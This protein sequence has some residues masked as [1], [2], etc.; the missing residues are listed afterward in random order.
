M[1]GVGKALGRA[2]RKNIM[3]R[4]AGSGLSLLVG[5]VGLARDL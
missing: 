5:L 1:T 3:L 4:R 2:L